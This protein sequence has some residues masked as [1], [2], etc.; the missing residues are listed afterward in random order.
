METQ[1]PS[2]NKKVIPFYRNATEKWPTSNYGIGPRRQS[3][4][5]RQRD[6]LERIL[7]FN[8]LQRSIV[9]KA[10]LSLIWSR[11]RLFADFMDLK[12]TL[13]QAK[14][15]I[16]LSLLVSRQYHFTKFCFSQR[17]SL[18]IIYKTRTQVWGCCSNEAYSMWSGSKYKEF[19]S[20]VYKN[21]RFYFMEN[22]KFQILN[23][24]FLGFLNK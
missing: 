14:K 22:Q 3:L 12:E 15:S 11:D 8:W 19:L 24:I 17:W 10:I 21:P 5:I 16:P 6:L 4:T 13:M 1:Q 2:W 20:I 18:F 9:K 23:A 7:S